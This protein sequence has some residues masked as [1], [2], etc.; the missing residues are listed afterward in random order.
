MTTVDIILTLLFRFHFR[1]LWVTKHK[2]F[3]CSAFGVC[4]AFAH[5]LL[6][7]D[8]ELILFIIFPF[9]AYVVVCIWT[10]CGDLTLISAC[11]KW[12]VS[13]RGCKIR[14]DLDNCKKAALL[15]SR[16]RSHTHTYIHTYRQT[17]PYYHQPKHI[18]LFLLA[19]LERQIDETS[20]KNHIQKINQ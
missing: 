5:P 10:I 19:K 4:R 13:S 20:E 3:V 11:G 15:I 17:E 6:K 12:C 1:L 14:K 2:R 9:A 8:F 18:K 7:Y 16:A